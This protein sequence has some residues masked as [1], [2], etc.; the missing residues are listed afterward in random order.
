MREAVELLRDEPY[1][2]EQLQTNQ[3]P[4][5]TSYPTLIRAR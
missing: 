1:N 4:P 5:M 3:A 2:P